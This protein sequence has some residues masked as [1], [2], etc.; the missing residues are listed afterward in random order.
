MHKAYESRFRNR[1][2]IEINYTE[3]YSDDKKNQ[4]LKKQ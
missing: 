1:K 2:Y 3:Y 4:M